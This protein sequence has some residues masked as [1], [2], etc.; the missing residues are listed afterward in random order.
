[1]VSGED[2]HNGLFPGRRLTKSRK[3]NGESECGHIYRMR[4]EET[5]S[6][7]ANSIKF[8]TG[9][10]VSQIAAHTAVGEYTARNKM[11]I[12]REV[13]TSLWCVRRP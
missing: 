3:W 6:R 8:T 7:L 11:R 12:V 2:Y 4:F 9:H 13:G 10:C 1:M 5:L